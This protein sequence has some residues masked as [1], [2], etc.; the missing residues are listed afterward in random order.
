M[1]IKRNMKVVLEG[2]NSFK[3]I[4]EYNSKISELKKILST[5]VLIL[6]GCFVEI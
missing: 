1:Q 2:L 4:S 6:I 5:F 3:D